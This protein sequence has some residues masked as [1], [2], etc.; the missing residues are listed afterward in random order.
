MLERL[1]GWSKASKC[2][3]LLEIL[4]KRLQV[5]QN[6]R[7]IQIKQ[8]RNDIVELLKNGRHKSC[9][10]RAKL[11]YKEQNLLDGYNLI[12][13]FCVCIMEHISYVRRNNDLPP[14]LNEAVSSLIFASA[15][16]ADLPELQ[17]L[18][19]LFAQRYGVEF[20]SAALDGNSDSSVGQQIIGK[21]SNKLATLDLKLKLMEEIAVE[22][23]LPWDSS[24]T[25]ADLGS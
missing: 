21:L 6:K 1:F 3:F 9:L 16:C 14:V 23:S 8:L 20:V 18:R 2:K 10:K 22:F 25:C 5:L 11:L 4:I 24:V 15:R 7:K 19:D 12:V 17:G 13:N